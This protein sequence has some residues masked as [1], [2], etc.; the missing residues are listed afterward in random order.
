MD[1]RVKVQEP[2]LHCGSCAEMAMECDATPNCKECGVWYGTWIDTTSNFW[3]T[4][5][6]VQNGEGQIKK[7]DHDRITVIKG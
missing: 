2:R 7:V 3:G 6:I 1:K 5:A 4:Y